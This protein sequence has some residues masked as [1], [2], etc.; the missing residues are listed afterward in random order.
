MK[1]EDFI[2]KLVSQFEEQVKSFSTEEL[3]GLKSGKLEIR[4][5]PTV[6]KEAG[7]RF[8]REPYRPIRNR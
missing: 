1:H 2:K 7:G 5:T 3:E 8:V 6:G 4:L